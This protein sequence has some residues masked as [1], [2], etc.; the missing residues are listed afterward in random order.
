MIIVN[1]YN[2]K[3][4]DF[5]IDLL[6]K[7]IIKEIFNLE[8]INL[9]ISVNISIVGLQKI[10]TLNNNL[11]GIDKA[12]DVLSF[13]NIQF[14]KNSDLKSLIKN[15]KIYNS[16]YDFSTK[17]IFLG[18]VV[19]CY[20]KIIFQSKKYNH[21]IKREY[22]FLLTHSIFHLLG[23]DH[24]NIKDEKNMFNKQEIILNKLKINR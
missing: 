16:I 18:D 22:A 8:K 15:K 14:K 17:S 9:N 13:P 19:I 10:K 4:F 7:K 2:N 6:S 11:R 5:D 20:N 1:I 24:M 3:K 12:T 23:Y 21:S